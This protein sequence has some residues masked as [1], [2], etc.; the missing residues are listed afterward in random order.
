M[1][2]RIIY[3]NITNYTIPQCNL[4][5]MQSRPISIKNPLILF[6]SKLIQSVAHDMEMIGTES[7]TVSSLFRQSGLYKPIIDHT[8]I[9][10]TI[11]LFSLKMTL[12]WKYITNPLFND[13]TNSPSSQRLCNSMFDVLLNKQSYLVFLSLHPLMFLFVWKQSQMR[14]FLKK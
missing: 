14:F 3:L 12:N 8:L 13:W 11:W 6:D 2:K 5:W 9:K 1:S 10:W 7:G 4:R